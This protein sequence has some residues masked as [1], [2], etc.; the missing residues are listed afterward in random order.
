MDC[1]VSF[2]TGDHPKGL[3]PSPSKKGFRVFT[4]ALRPFYI[5]DCGV[6][7]GIEKRY[8]FRKRLDSFAGY[9]IAALGWFF[10]GVYG[11]D[12]VRAKFFGKPDFI[13]RGGHAKLWAWSC[14]SDQAFPFHAFGSST[15]CDEC[16]F[17][18][19]DWEFIGFQMGTGKW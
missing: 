10:S 16:N 6:Y 18:L 14:F 12:V 1:L 2:G 3:F 8:D 7:F 11:L 9:R 5:A 13:Y 19:L 15:L 4:C 17:A